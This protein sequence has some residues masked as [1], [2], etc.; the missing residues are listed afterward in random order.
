MGPLLGG[1]LTTDYSWRWSFGINVPLG[2]LIVAGVLLFVAPTPRARGRVD[3]D[4]VGALLS[5]IGFGGLAYGLIEG[6]SYGWW[7]PIGDVSLLGLSPVPIALAVAALA[8]GAFVARAVAGRRRGKPGLVD[9]D[10][11]SIPSFAAGNVAALIISLGEFGILFALPLWLQNVL[12]YSAFETGVLLLALALGSFL[13]SGA[14]A[15]LTER[16][17]P[18][19]MVRMGIVLEIVGV[20]GL[21]FV[22]SPT[23]SAWSL[24]PLLAVYGVGVGLATA[25]IT[26]VVLADV[27]VAR[28]GEASGIQSTARQIGS[29]MGI[30]ILGTVLFAGL[31]GGTRDGLSAAGLPAGQVDALTAAVTD[32]AGAVIAPLAA[33]PATAVVAEV[34]RTALSTATATAALV[35]AGALVLGLLASLR[36]RPARQPATRWSRHA[37]RPSAPS[38]TLG[39]TSEPETCSTTTVTLLL[40][41]PMGRHR[42]LTLPSAPGG[43]P[44]WLNRPRKT[45]PRS[46]RRP[47]PCPTPC[48]TPGSTRPCWR[49]H[50]HHARR[51][52]PTAPAGR[53]GWAWAV[54]CDSAP[55]RLAASRAPP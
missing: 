24:V 22:V 31:A 40:S 13:A 18:L 43:D 28:S 48:P 52:S 33:D 37:R 1:W 23:T 51:R 41:R 55:R 26:N 12:E 20:G 36:I 7:T 50:P 14:G 25:Q 5:V 42:N 4:P 19:Q 30:A 11:F 2:V 44:R 10:L 15:V 53:P 32:S 46:I 49:P 35:A 39:R 38:A 8:L 3:L 17:G 45:R 16:I 6:R 34:A 27:P 21:G 47:I 9:I 29:A 54:P